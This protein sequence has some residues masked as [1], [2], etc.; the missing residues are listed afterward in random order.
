MPEGANRCRIAAIC[1][2][3]SGHVKGHASRR[4]SPV[5]VLRSALTSTFLVELKGIE[6][7]R[8]RRSESI[9]ALSML[10]G[11]AA[12]SVL[13]TAYAQGALSANRDGRGSRARFGSVGTEWDGKALGPGVRSSE[14]PGQH[15]RL[16]AA[17]GPRRGLWRRTEPLAQGDAPARNLQIDVDEDRGVVGGRDPRALLL[18]LL[19]DAP[20]LRRVDVGG[21]APQAVALETA[22]HDPGGEGV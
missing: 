6:E 20:V 18:D 2:S 3:R 8:N 21:G 1:G 13:K 9:S 15:L 7:T 22:A 14:A 10:V 4:A 16:R 17:S 11:E 12:S 19:V 5:D